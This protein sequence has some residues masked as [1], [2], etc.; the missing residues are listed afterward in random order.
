MPSMPARISITGMLLISGAVIADA[1]SDRMVDGQAAYQAYCA[2]CHDTGEMDAPITT[3]AEDW[4]IRSHLWEAVLFEHA[5]QGYLDMPAKGGA[6][7]ASN[8]EVKAAAEY[9][10]TITHPQL[11]HD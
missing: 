6:D 3:R 11:T 10:V 4:V 7:D 9:M 5:E 1:P 8:Y 2:A